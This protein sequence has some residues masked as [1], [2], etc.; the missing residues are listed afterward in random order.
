LHVV[1]ELTG[2][3]QFRLG[4]FAFSLAALFLSSA[5]RRRDHH[6]AIKGKS[7]PDVARLARGGKAASPLVS[8]RSG[9]APAGR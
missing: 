9:V 1:D 7:A 2:H 3:G 6:G 5:R 8:G 4:A